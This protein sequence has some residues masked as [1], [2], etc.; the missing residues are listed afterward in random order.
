M[1]VRARYQSEANRIVAERIAHLRSLTHEQAASLPELSDCEDL[2]LD[3]NN[4]AVMVVAQRDTY[5]LPGAVL[6]T[7]TVVRRGF[8]GIASYHTERGLVFAP[9]VAVREATELE[10]R[11]AG[12]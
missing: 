1:A 5:L 6:V 10:L 2:V 7:V 9:N 12:G 3:G 4:C 11:A 8:L